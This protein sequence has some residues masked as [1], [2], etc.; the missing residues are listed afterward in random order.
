[1]TGIM[2][3]QSRIAP[4]PRSMW[5]MVLMACATVAVAQSPAAA[6]WYDKY[7]CP[8]ECNINDHL[9]GG[10]IA[11][12][13]SG[14]DREIYWCRRGDPVYGPLVRPLAMRGAG[15]GEVNRWDSKY[16]SGCEVIT[17]Q[18]INNPQPGPFTCSWDFA[19]PSSQW[20]GGMGSPRVDVIKNNALFCTVRAYP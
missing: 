10:C 6:A 13:C 4:V 7:G 19:W 1:M 9:G 18:S 14:H 12:K 17:K 11:T 20:L 8:A 16:D 15:C 5:L 3:R 2:E